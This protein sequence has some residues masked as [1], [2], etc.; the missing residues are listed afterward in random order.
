MFMSFPSSSLRGL[1]ITALDAVV[2]EKSRTVGGIRIRWFE[3]F[4]E[5][6]EKLD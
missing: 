1:A 4:D 3:T 6:V 2:D 5:K